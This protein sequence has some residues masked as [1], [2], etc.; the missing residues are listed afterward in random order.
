M[1]LQERVR[2]R[3]GPLR[4]AH[5]NPV[6]FPPSAPLIAHLDTSD[7]FF[8]QWRSTPF[9][10][11]GQAARDRRLLLLRAASARQGE[12]GYLTLPRTTAAPAPGPAPPLLACLLA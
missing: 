2:A 11:R 7:F 8:V 5:G 4:N 1:I 12:R 6:R 3:R 9:V 10:Y